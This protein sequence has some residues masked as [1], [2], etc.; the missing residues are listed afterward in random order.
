MHLVLREVGDRVD[1]RVP[2]GPDAERGQDQAGRDD[3]GPRWR[4]EKVMIAS[5]MGA[6]RPG[7]F[8]RYFAGSRSSFDSH[9]P[10]QRKTTRPETTTRFG[11]PIEPS[12]MSGHGAGLLALRERAIL[13]AESSERLGGAR[14]LA[15]VGRAGSRRCAAIASPRRAEVAGGEARVQP[16]LGVEQEGPGDRDA[17]TRLEAP[18][19]RVEVAAARAQDDLD[20]VEHAGHALDEDDLALAPVSTTADCGT[21]STWPAG[22]IGDHARP[23]LHPAALAHMTRR[24]DRP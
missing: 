10:Q 20:A 4:I 3:H 19:D 23:Q 15:L 2:R 8:A 22:A 16:G 12:A 5:I 24:R 14:R 1:R 21:A 11:V 17:L 13:G 7:S 9:P 6:L 18:D